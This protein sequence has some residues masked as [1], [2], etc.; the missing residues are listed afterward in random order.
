[1]H[2]GAPPAPKK[3][4]AAETR[5]LSWL[6][7]AREIVGLPTS[8]VRWEADTLAATAMGLA[9]H[10]PYTVQLSGLAV[11]VRPGSMAFLARSE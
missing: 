1:M 9:S 11:E 3:L 5:S 6:V 10:A 4:S 7:W 2:A 8:G